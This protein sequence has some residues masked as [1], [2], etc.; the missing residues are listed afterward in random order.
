MCIRRLTD[1]VALQSS[2]GKSGSCFFFTADMR[3]VIKTISAEELAS[4]EAMAPHYYAHAQAVRSSLLCRVVGL[5]S[6]AIENHS[7]P[8][9]TQEAMV[10]LAMG[11]A[12]GQSA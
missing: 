3:F 4:A 12:T 5:Y 10:R 8:P 11:L 1:A 6:L 9:S 2:P 7:A